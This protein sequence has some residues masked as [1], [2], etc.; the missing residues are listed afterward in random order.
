MLVFVPLVACVLA[1]PESCNATSDQALVRAEGEQEVAAERAMSNDDKKGAAET[2]GCED[3]AAIPLKKLPPIE[4]TRYSMSVTYDEG[5]REWVPVPFPRVPDRTGARIEWRGLSAHAALD[6]SH[7]YRFLAIATG[8]R[9]LKGS[10][11]WS[12]EYVF[13]VLCVSRQ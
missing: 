1:M 13:E 11:R 6:R 5:S 7:T 8:K 2:S 9:V 10:K 12:T 4:G 3:A